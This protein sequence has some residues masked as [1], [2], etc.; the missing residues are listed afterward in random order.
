MP[1]ATCPP[2]LFSNKRCLWSRFMMHQR[3]GSRD[4][5]L[6]MSLSTLGPQSSKASQSLS[7]PDCFE[8]QQLG[9]WRSGLIAECPHEFFAFCSLRISCIS[10]SLRRCFKEPLV[11]HSQ[12]WRRRPILLLASLATTMYCGTLAM[13]RKQHHTSLRGWVLSIKHI[14][15]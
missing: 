7:F 8:R 14:E 9:R 12:I 3:I 1:R 2:C 5:D 10:K 13:P 11:Q 4:Q 6:S 15:A